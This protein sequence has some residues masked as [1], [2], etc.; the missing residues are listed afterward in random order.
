MIELQRG[1]RERKKGTSFQRKKERG[2]T[3]FQETTDFGGKEK[4]TL[5]M[6]NHYGGNN[7]R[8]A[9]KK[10]KK[11]TVRPQSRC[12]NPACIGNRRARKRTLQSNEEKSCRKPARSRR[13]QAETLHVT[14]P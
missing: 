3:F 7:A 8:K 14:S 5:L 13:T 4:E 1:F 11:V 6:S 10:K 9:K 2:G 12:K